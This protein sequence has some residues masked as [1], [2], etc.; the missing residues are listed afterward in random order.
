MTHLD[1]L[2]DPISRMVKELPQGKLSSIARVPGRSLERLVWA[3][4]WGVFRRCE[5]EEGFPPQLSAVVAHHPQLV[6]VADDEAGCLFREVQYQRF[7]DADHR[8]AGVRIHLWA[9][10]A[11]GGRTRVRLDM[12]VDEWRS[13]RP[14]ARGRG[15][16][17]GPSHRGAPDS[18]QASAVPPQRGV[19]RDVTFHRRGPGGSAGQDRGRSGPG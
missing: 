14:L 2:V 17:T 7:A 16:L 3:G 18:G 11:A 6:D 5:P 10:P 9:R 15:R 1:K 19:R 13:F 4:T 8:T 12:P